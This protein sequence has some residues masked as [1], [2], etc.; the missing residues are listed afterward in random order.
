LGNRWADIAA[1]I[2]GRTENMVKNHWNATARRKDL[3]VARDGGS[4]VLREHLLRKQ[5]VA[6]GSSLDPAA[7]VQSRMAKQSQTAT[8]LQLQKQ[9]GIVS[10]AY[11]NSSRSLGL[12]VLRV[13]KDDD[14]DETAANEGAAG[15]AQRFQP[16]RHSQQHTHTHR[17][18][19]TREQLSACFHLPLAAATP[20]LGVGPTFLKEQCRKYGIKRW[21]HRHLKSLD[22]LIAH[23]K[24]QA[25]GV[26]PGGAVHVASPVTP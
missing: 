23:E 19:F 8:H 3:P 17:V 22:Q 1:R 15:G 18:A 5:I 9:L 21:P 20:K 11:I 16:Q 2:P 24:K 7:Y 14:D 4:L 25:R 10:A 13:N 12:R 26:S 6:D